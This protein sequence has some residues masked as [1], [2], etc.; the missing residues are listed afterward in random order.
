MSSGG[1]GRG[2]NTYNYPVVVASP[3]RW[4]LPSPNHVLKANRSEKNHNKIK[5]I[6]LW[7]EGGGG[8]DDAGHLA[9]AEAIRSFQWRRWRRSV[10]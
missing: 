2:I 1:E 4:F 9:S 10:R 6:E 3:T 7:K 8:L 5:R